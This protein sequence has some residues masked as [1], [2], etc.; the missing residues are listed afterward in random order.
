MSEYLYSE[1][2]KHGRGRKAKNHQD[3]QPGELSLK[4]LINGSLSSLI[5]NHSPIKS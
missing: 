1:G 3:F 2:R 4:F 5:K